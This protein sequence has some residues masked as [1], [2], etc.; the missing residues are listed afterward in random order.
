MLAAAQVVDHV[1]QCTR[2]VAALLAAT[3]TD[4]AWPLTLDELPAAR[5]YAGDEDIAPVTV[6]ELPLLEH[7]LSVQAELRV[8][9]VAAIDE[10]M[11]DLTSQFIAAVYAP[12]RRAQRTSFLLALSRI[13]RSLEG[14]NQSRVGAVDVTF[15]ARYR[16]RADQPD[17]IR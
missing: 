11:H 7:R 6:H 13:E 8:Q 5:V 16:T 10:A 14:D 17:V 4:R 1:A 12:A 15:E 2:D 9:A 3:H